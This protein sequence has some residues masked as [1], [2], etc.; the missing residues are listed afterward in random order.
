MGEQ[1]DDCQLRVVQMGG[2]KAFFELLQ[3]YRIERESIDKRYRSEAVRWYAR[4]MVNRVEGKE[5]KEQPPPKD[6]D[7]RISRVK[8]VWK[9]WIEKKP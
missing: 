7:E 6:W 5:F 8:V 4:R 2:N 1:W 9:E 3:E